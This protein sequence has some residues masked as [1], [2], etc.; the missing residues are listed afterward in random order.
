LPEFLRSQA[1][2]DRPFELRPLEAASNPLHPVAQP[3][4]RM[5]WIKANGTLP[6]DPALH[7]YLLAY[8]SD[9]AFLTT[10]MLPHAVSWLSR[11]M[12]VASIDHS[13]WFHENVRVDDWLLHVVD[14]PKAHGGR[15]LVRG[16]VFTHDG[17][18]VAST[19]QEG[20]IRR[21][22]KP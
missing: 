12:Q 11:G 13:M 16:R 5:F 10:A 18:L 8:L 1:V 14:S 4:T 19:A 7:R 22:A 2:A 20:L 21:R 6:D 9:F 17:R 3:P 15:G